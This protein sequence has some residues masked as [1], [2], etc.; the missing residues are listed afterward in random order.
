MFLFKRPLVFDLGVVIN[1][2][3]KTTLRPRA[4]PVKNGPIYLFGLNPDSLGKIE[5]AALKREK[6][7]NNWSIDS[8]LST[9]YEIVFLNKMER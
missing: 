3:R 1:I 6:A 4:F 5:K 8:R 2:L 7:A 9:G